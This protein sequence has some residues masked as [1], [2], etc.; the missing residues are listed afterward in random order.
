MEL[1]KRIGDLK[2][3]QTKEI[4]CSEESLKSSVNP[5]L[6]ERKIKEAIERMNIMSKKKKKNKK[7]THSF[8]FIF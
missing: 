4:K 7:Q 5:S 2:I 6:V 8:S 3:C 1:F